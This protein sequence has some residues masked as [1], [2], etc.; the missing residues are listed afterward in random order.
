MILNTAI[1]IV[2]ANS[3]L[4]VI[5]LSLFKITR[6]AF[7]VNS[8]MI[9]GITIGVWHYI[10]SILIFSKYLLSFFIPTSLGNTLF[11]VYF[12][13]ETATSINEKYKVNFK[14]KR[15]A[16]T[17][18]NIKRGASV[19]GAAGSGKTESVIYNFLQH[20]SKYSFCGIIH[21]YKDFELTEMPIRCLKTAN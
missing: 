1:S 15:R 8:I 21:D 13:K 17:I 4:L 14:L 2:I 9:L 19:I 18:E 3:L 6:K 7:M 10:D 20:F 11:Y 5:F 16:L 12:Q